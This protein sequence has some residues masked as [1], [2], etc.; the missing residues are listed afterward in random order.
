VGPGRGCSDS[1]GKLVDPVRNR[2]EEQDLLIEGERIA[3]ILR[4]GSSRKQGPSQKNRCTKPP[5][6]PGLWICMFT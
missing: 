4:A 1:R 5:G 2:V 6:V 3:K